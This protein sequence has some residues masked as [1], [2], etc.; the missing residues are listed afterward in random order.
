MR[1]AGRA[2]ELARLLA[3]QRNTQLDGWRAL[4]VVGVMWHHW[5]PAAWH[6]PFP[7]EIGLFF[8]LTLSGFLITRILLDQRADGESRGGR[9]RVAAYQEFQRRRMSRILAPCYAAMCFAIV[10][11]APDIRTHAPAYFAQ[12]ANFHMAWLAEWPSGTAHFWTLAIQMQ[13]YLVWPMLVFWA[14]QRALGGGFAACIVLAPISRWAIDR[15]LPGIHH[16]EAISLTALD[17]LGAGAWLAWALQ[18]GMSAG[19]RRFT[20]V[21]GLAGAGYVTLY[22]CHHAG[23][24]CGGL[25]YLQQ[26]LLAVAFAGVISSTL[27][28]F[29]GVT[30]KLLDHPAVQ[31]V[32]SLS[33]GLYLFHAAVPLLVGKLLPFLWWPAFDGP[34]AI[35]KLGVFAAVSWGAALLCWRYFEGPDRWR[36]PGSAVAICPGFRVSPQ[37]DA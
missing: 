9:W 37:E 3:A 4:A 36:L 5:S 1:D 6:G 33:Y 15:W 24:A 22:M 25:G 10:V 34:L 32:G 21:A 28:G 18:R 35:I 11:G 23:A 16:S 14:P 7:F 13:F 20:R 30:A 27:A 8:F 2:W 12:I 19:D 29:S 17:Y 31:R 26:T